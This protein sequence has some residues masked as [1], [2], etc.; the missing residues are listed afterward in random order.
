M[1][2]RPRKSTDRS[3]GLS[4][5]SFLVLA[6]SV[7]LGR[8]SLPPLDS[9]ERPDTALG[10]TRRLI[11]APRRFGPGDANLMWTELDPSG[12]A[13]VRMWVPDSEE[14]AAELNAFASA[15]A[16]VDWDNV[17]IADVPMPGD[18]TA[19]RRFELVA[20][21]SAKF[22]EVEPLES[23]F[24]VRFGKVGT[25]GQVQ[26]KSFAT[27]EASRK[28]MD[29]L[30]AEK[31]AKGYVEVSSD[32]DRPKPKTKRRPGQGPPPDWTTP[33][34]W[35]EV[36][37]E[38]EPYVPRGREVAAPS[39][40]ELDAFETA[41]GFRL[42]A[43][44]RA[45]LS[46]FGPGTFGTFHVI[47]APGAPGP[48]DLGRAQADFAEF[49]ESLDFVSDVQQQAEP[50]THMVV[51]GEDVI[52]CFY[53][54]DFEDVRDPATHEYAIRK[55]DYE[56]YTCPV[57]AASFPEFI[58]DYVLGDRRREEDGDESERKSYSPETRKKGD[59]AG[60]GSVKE[61]PK[62]VASSKAKR[63]P[64]AE[65]DFMMAIVAAP[66]DSAPWLA[67]ADWLDGH[68]DKLGPLIR[69]RL[70]GPET[71]DP[72]REAKLID[73]L[74]KSWDKE[75]VAAGLLPAMLKRLGDR[76]Q[77]YANDAGQIYHIRIA[78]DLV[79][80]R[81]LN[82]FVAYPALRS[83]EFEDHRLSC[84]ELEAVSRISAVRE[85]HLHSGA[86]D[87]DL[88]TVSRMLGL[89]NLC[90]CKSRVRGAGLRHLAAL[91]SLEHLHLGGPESEEWRMPA[92]ALAHLEAL[93]AL[94]SLHLGS[95]GFG[96]E[97]LARVARLGELEYLGFDRNPIRD[98]HLS[99]LAGL[100]N[101]QC[102]DLSE[103]EIT[104]AGLAHL[105]PLSKLERL[106]LGDR[107]IGDAGLAWVGTL[108]NL[109]ALTIRD[110]LN[111]PTVTDAGLAHIRGLVHLVE[112]KC[113][114][115]N[116]SDDALAHLSGLTA[117][118]S[119]DL[120]GNRRIV[121]PGLA[122]LSSLSRLKRLNLSN[123]GITSAA[124]PRLIALKSLEEIMSANCK[125]S[126][127]ARRQLRAAFPKATL[128][129]E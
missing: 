2:R 7:T 58:N 48:R 76:S 103:T 80:A 71:A 100:V 102:L 52:P 69:L 23:G 124:V 47:Y 63:S 53:G 33:E 68:K 4:R 126:E 70:G 30:V 89:Q 104:G 34:A 127:K 101:L 122:H 14:E 10:P 11:L 83:L 45:F 46:V 96:G 93:P 3:E 43:S 113:D 55:Y 36:F 108:T 27:A 129:P 37:D 41:T 28:A 98:D 40:A 75:L 9:D 128:W 97:A 118:E 125:I 107:P 8:F 31:V 94:R 78:K 25:N 57:V 64:A 32:R 79:N 91:P 85:L 87:D 17:I 106:R 22:W 42:P 29:K 21:S 92:D 44:Y 119:L 115:T 60:S 50:I 49:A 19:T 18:S 66:D 84:E 77:I 120:S 35:Q 117:L 13:S 112:L 6:G 121:G 105:G 16:K 12:E 95:H 67:Y 5:R 86:S 116:L 15:A 26:E 88:A 114:W 20:G 62:P 24:R 90:L 109:R 1:A 38:L 51:F 59:K 82:A 74:A 110:D 123:T 72:V 54:W 56:Y 111:A 81:L 65:R 39:P 73:G 61:A 99:H